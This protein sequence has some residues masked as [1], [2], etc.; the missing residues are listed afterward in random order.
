MY[1]KMVLKGLFIASF[2]L[3]IVGIIK[4]KKGEKE[5]GNA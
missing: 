2:F 3:A 1:K 4:Y 5:Y